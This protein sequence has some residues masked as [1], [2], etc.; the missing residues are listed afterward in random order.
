MKSDLITYIRAPE[1]LLGAETYSTAV[2]IWS[3]GCIF[4]ELLLKEPVFQAK[5]EIELVSMIIKLLG[6][7]TTSTWPNFKDLPLAKSLSLPPS[8]PSQ[9]PRKFP[10]LSSA[11]LDLLSQLLTYDPEKRIS[12]VEALNHPYFR[13]V[14][15]KE[16][17]DGAL[18]CAFTAKHR[19]QSIQISSRLSPPLLRERSKFS[20]LFGPLSS[21]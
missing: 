9:L 18:T 16:K 8:H 1:I 14:Q 6:P 11:G 3:V 21:F 10:Y 7:P 5:N 19:L 13:Q 17:I 12:A 15:S 4:G 2:D 20:L